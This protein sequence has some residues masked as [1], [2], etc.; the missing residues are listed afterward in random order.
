M[1]AAD[2]VLADEVDSLQVVA[3][4]VR[5]GRGQA[6][7]GLKRSSTTITIVWYA[8]LPW[9]AVVRTWRRM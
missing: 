9:P 6:M 3:P 5:T 8:V 2:R 1:G 7:P 4:S